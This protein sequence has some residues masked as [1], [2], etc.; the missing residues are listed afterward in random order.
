MLAKPAIP[1]APGLETIATAGRERILALDDAAELLDVLA[2]GVARALEVAGGVVPGAGDL[3]RELER[4]QAGGRWPVAAGAAAELE[5]SL[6]VATGLRVPDVPWALGHTWRSLYPAI[7]T[8]FGHGGLPAGRWPAFR[9]LAIEM[10]R[11]AFGPPVRNAARLLALVEAGRVD[12]RNVAGRH[13]QNVDAV[14]DAVIPPP[15]AHRTNPLVRGLLD[16][17]HVRVAGV[18]RGLDVDLD[19]SCR[20]AD[21]SITPGLA[22][23]GRLTEDAVIGNDTLSRTLHP[24]ADRW[25][26]RLAAPVPVG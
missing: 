5:H 18:Q 13:P 7:V 1:L 23:I 3:A 2:T 21:G 8:R 16:A 4:V 22:A 17:G 26:A 15:G 11:I 14:I 24:E 10:E 12:L 9:R 25:A 20:A 19:L 6:E